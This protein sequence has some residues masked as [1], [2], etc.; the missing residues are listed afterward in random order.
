MMTRIYMINDYGEHGPENIRVAV[1]ANG[2]REAARE[3]L[4]DSRDG[5]YCADV[6]A[7]LEKHLGA[8]DPCSLSL[9]RG[10]GGLQLHIVDAVD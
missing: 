4:K 6:M 10:W 8:D 7:N 1:T 3:Y 2:I 5:S 9:R